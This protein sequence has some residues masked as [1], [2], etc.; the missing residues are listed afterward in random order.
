MTYRVYYSKES[1]KYLSR[2]TPS[3]IK[4]LFSRI[5]KLA[6]NPFADDNNIAKLTGTKS[7]YR[8]RIGDTR[9]IYYIDR[10]KRVI[11]ITKI[12]PRGSVY[13]H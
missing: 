12:A 13:S 5:E 9:V 1:V 11:Y 6:K 7:S 10:E 4:R 2:L 3:S 8:I